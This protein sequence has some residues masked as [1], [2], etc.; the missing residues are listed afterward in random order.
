MP[1]QLTRTLNSPYIA[2]TILPQTP[3]QTQT[4]ILQ[5]SSLC[6]VS[7]PSQTHHLFPT[8]PTPTLWPVL[9]SR[10][11]QEECL[12]VMKE[13]LKL[14]LAHHVFPSQPDYGSELF[15]LEIP[16]KNPPNFPIQ[17]ANVHINIME[18]SNLLVVLIPQKEVVGA[19][20]TFN[21][22]PTGNL[23]PEIKLNASPLSMEDVWAME[24][25][26]LWR[27]WM[28]ALPQMNERAKR[29]GIFPP[30]TIPSVDM[31]II[32][33]NVRGAASKEFI[34]HAREIINNHNPDVFILLETKA[35]N[36]CAEYTVKKLGF[37]EHRTIEAE[38]LKGGIRVMW[39]CPASLVDFVTEPPHVFHALFKFSPTT[40]ET[41]I[42][43]IHAPTTTAA[44][45]NLW[46]AMKDSIPPSTTPRLVIGDMNEITRQ[47]E[48]VGGRPIT[49]SQ[50]QVYAEWVE[51]E[52]LIDLNFN[53]PKF[54]W[55]NGQEGLNLI[56]ER[57]DKALANAKWM[58]EHPNTQDKGKRQGEIKQNIHW[59]RPA[60]GSA[61]LNIDGAWRSEEN[62]GAGAV[63]RDLYAGWM[64]RG[65]WKFKARN[66]EEAEL[67]AIK[68]GME[69]AIKE[70]L[71]KV[72]VET[73]AQSLKSTTIEHIDKQERHELA[74]ILSDIGEL[75]KGPC[76]FDF[77]YIRREANTVAHRLAQLAFVM[78]EEIILHNS[79]PAFVKNAYEID[80]V[81]SCI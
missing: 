54:T 31:K 38:G 53:G 46:N 63:I 76:K 71:R 67:L 45:N 15:S 49:N 39:N 73:D 66:P 43:G 1:R 4:K 22:V 11:L 41:L 75:L 70:E 14:I 56:R 52:G 65:S 24:K 78:E 9:A 64:V 2:P 17:F 29:L 72:T 33:W 59:E 42:T 26:H 55:S 37:Q 47:L 74:A 16:S 20:L 77:K 32:L 40:E 68:G 10:T 79:V 60:S 69:L 62:A 13:G 51:R 44:K 57:L 35:T 58:E 5:P 48:K 7:P 12:N 27:D 80:M 8:V 50:G 34:S 81:E 30:F 18:P 23:V 25:L 36:Q 28:D 19:S 61:K 3:T 6:R 21:F